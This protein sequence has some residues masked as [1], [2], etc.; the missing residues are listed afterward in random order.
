MT[1]ELEFDNEARA[2]KV[3]YAM[4]QLALWRD[5]G[6]EAAGNY[7]AYLIDY[8]YDLYADAEDA[9]AVLESYYLD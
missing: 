2:A 7:V 8:D 4:D 1:A 3:E 5:H 6:N 9:L